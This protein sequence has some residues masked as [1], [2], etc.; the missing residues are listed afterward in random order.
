[1]AK[2]REQYKCSVCEGLSPKWQGQCPHCGAW[3]T[4][5]VY[6][7]PETPKRRSKGVPATFHS[8]S[9]PEY[10]R[11]YRSGIEE[12]DRVVG[13]GITEGS[14]LL[15]SGDPGVGKSTIALQLCKQYLEQGLE[16]CY[17]SG[18]ESVSQLALRANR[19]GFAGA[20]LKISNETGVG[21][22]V[23]GLERKSRR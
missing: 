5:E 12:F 8:L 16:M 18:E 20:N 11:R 9:V 17:F 1:M 10:P 15:L 4:L 6:T 2:I 23:A 14:I 22:I 19:L 7:D 3:N 13:G 21:N